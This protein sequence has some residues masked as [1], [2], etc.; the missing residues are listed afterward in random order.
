M[1]FLPGGAIVAWRRP[2]VVH[3][4]TPLM[5]WKKEGWNNQLWTVLGVKFLQS[6][7]HKTI[8]L[9]NLFK[10]V[11]GGMMTTDFLIHD[12]FIENV[13]SGLYELKLFSLIYF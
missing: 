11:N 10:A 12:D 1:E 13:D 9:R 3:F 2:D 7:S 6:P 5:K 8:K 4:T